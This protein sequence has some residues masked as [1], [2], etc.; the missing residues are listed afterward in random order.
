MSENKIIKDDIISFAN[1]FDLY[2]HL[3]NKSILITG[4]TGLIGSI[5]AKC[6]NELNEKGD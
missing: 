3:K 6:L 5:T 4:I 1:S 2:N